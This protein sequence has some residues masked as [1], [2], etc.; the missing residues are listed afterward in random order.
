MLP[1]QEP[2]STGDVRHALQHNV[3]A[4]PDAVEDILGD[5]IE[6]TSTLAKNDASKSAEARKTAQEAQ[7]VAIGEDV[8]PMVKEI[9]MDPPV[10]I[11]IPEMEMQ[12]VDQVK[13]R[14][15][16]PF[17]GSHTILNAQYFPF[18]WKR[19]PPPLSIRCVGFAKGG[20]Q[21]RGRV[22][23]DVSSDVIV[24]STSRKMLPT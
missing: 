14:P 2:S 22:S 6:D 20:F 16:H 5:A 19:K 3:P 10:D 17:F 7:L 9:S 11:V 12:E 23:K 24:D 13:A 21:C 15:L 8:H 1:S 18:F 4:T